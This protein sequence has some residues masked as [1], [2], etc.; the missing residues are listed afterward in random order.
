LAGWRVK[1]VA[2]THKKTHPPPAV[3]SN[4]DSCKS[5]QMTG[6]SPGWDAVQSLE[7]E[8][9]HTHIHAR[10]RARLA[11]YIRG[12]TKGSII[13]PAGRDPHKG[14]RGRYKVVPYY[15]RSRHFSS[16]RTLVRLDEIVTSDDLLMTC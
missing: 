5:D 11:A 4:P 6:D 16:V 3:I 9:V 8:P 2:S 7:C 13:S 12:S 14:S 10:T 1:G 15:K